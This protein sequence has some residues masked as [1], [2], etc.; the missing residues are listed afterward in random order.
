ML[1]KNRIVRGSE[2]RQMIQI[3]IPQVA[4]RT[5]KI[6]YRIYDQDGNRQPMAELEA[7]QSLQN[8][9]SAYPYSSE[10]DHVR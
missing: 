9:L 10:H 1:L 4:Y 8:I 5:W 6:E 3:D 7:E 2:V